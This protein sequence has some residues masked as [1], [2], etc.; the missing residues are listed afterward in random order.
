[1][2]PNLSANVLEDLQINEI[3]VQKDNYLFD[4]STR[5][6]ACPGNDQ[7]TLTITCVP[8]GNSSKFGLRQPRVK[9]GAG[10]R[11]SCLLFSPYSPSTLFI[12][13]QNGAAYIFD[14]PEKQLNRDLS[15][16]AAT[17]DFKDE[18]KC[19][20]YHP[21][22]RD[23]IIIG[24]RSG[25]LQV[26]DKKLGEPLAV[27][28]HGRPLNAVAWSDDGKLVF[29]LYVDMVLKVWDV[30][31][32][33]SLCEVKV[34][35]ARGL[36]FLQSLPN[37]RV[38]VSFSAS[39][40][41][42][43]RIYDEK[44]ASL[45]S[46]Q[47]GVN[48][49][50]LSVTLHFSGL[51]IANAS[52]E[53]KLYLIDS[54]T[55]QDVCV[56]THSVGIDNASFDHIKP[57]P[58]GNVVVRC[59]LLNITNCISRVNFT[60]PKTPIEFPPYPIYETSVDANAWAEG[61]DGELK[62]V[63]L[64]P[65]AKPQETVVEEKKAQGPQTFY[66]YLKC[67]PDPPS[68]YY[69]DLPVG[70]APNPEFNEIVCNGKEF[71]FIGAS[72]TPQIYFLPLGKPGRFPAKCV[73]QITDPHG[74]GIGTMSYSPFDDRLFVSGGDDCKCKLW[75]LPN[76]WVNP[77]HDPIITLNH[78]RKV[79]I[80][81]FSECTN[82]LLLTATPQPELYMWDLNNEKQIRNFSSLCK[83]PIQ[84]V[85][86]NE[87]S[88]QVFV[89]ERNG[90][91]FSFDPRTNSPQVQET[92]AHPNGGR[93]R[94]L[95]NIPDFGYLASFGS[96]SR[97]ERQ[98]SIWDVKNLEK[99]LKSVEFDT[100]TGSLLPL[101]E[102]GAGLIYLGGKGDG[103]I[104]Y[105]ELAHD[106]RIIA[107][108]GA[109][110]TS[111]PE[112][113][114]T[115]L[116]RKMCDIMGCECSR[117]LKLATES[118]HMLHWRI[119]RTHNEFFQDAIYPPVRNTSKPLFEIVDWENGAQEVYPMVDFQ[120]ANTKKFSEVAH[121]F[122]KQVKRKTLQEI[123]EENKTTGPMTMEDIIAAAPE[124]STSDDDESSSSENW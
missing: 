64:V 14:L 35:A 2:Y 4:V 48:G 37:R 90:R 103:H 22:V 53:T 21:L 27:L 82:H 59:S 24:F 118:M 6:Y 108:Q 114:L 34:S 84:D 62:T 96:S 119:L 55:L 75:K 44:A 67:N 66:K 121:L 88:S 41:Q 39:G 30:R 47:V 102:E 33:E 11:A 123:Q 100:S 115:L 117:M 61:N 77:L 89:I 97:G 9:V 94:R 45:A 23:L 38:L 70:Q 60:V 42:E 107:S 19:A 50:P 8:I 68:Q 58:D 95:L 36:G 106:E 29:A 49:T 85:C 104:R 72:K 111:E 18:I 86:M 76:E 46:R 7:R 109:Y 122:N 80:A 56:Y 17:K 71:A 16:P 52:R 73:A 74:S 26:F 91:L 65:T 57:D 101:Y 87:F 25:K 32:K 10:Q 93:H 69:I 113:G 120:P 83:E 124:I 5:Y 105:V 92:I 112:R 98:L 15:K 110:E 28:E 116:P 31:K 12:G 1:M 13:T 78:N 81:K 51:I 40:K 54:Q 79:T 99:P 20:A 63:Q 3:D 43:L